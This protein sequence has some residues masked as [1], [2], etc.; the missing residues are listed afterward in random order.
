MSTPLL[1]RCSPLSAWISPKQ[2]ETNT[3]LAAKAIKAGPGTDARM[4][5]IRYGGTCPGCPGVVVLSS[6]DRIKP[7]KVEAGDKGSGR[8]A[9]GRQYKKKYELNK[10]SK[11]RCRKT[12]ETNVDGKIFISKTLSAAGV[13]RALRAMGVSVDDFKEAYHKNGGRRSRY[14][15]PTREEV[16][17]VEAFQET[18]DL[19]ALRKMLGGCGQNKAYATVARVVAHQARAR[20]EKAA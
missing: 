4:A 10:G 20:K 1:Y 16:A 5:G 14:A 2:C 19:A 7:R 8:K 13:E 17:A 15:A 3:K 9:R 12:K 11:E 6:R 18:G